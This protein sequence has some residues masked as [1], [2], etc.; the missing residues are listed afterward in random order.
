MSYEDFDRAMDKLWKLNSPEQEAY[1]DILRIKISNQE[2]Q[3]CKISGVQA[4]VARNKLGHLKKELAHVENRLNLGFERN[5]A[6]TRLLNATRKAREN[7]LSNPSELIEALENWDVFA[8]RLDRHLAEAAK[9]RIRVAR[10]RWPDASIKARVQL[11]RGLASSS[12]RRWLVWKPMNFLL[13]GLSKVSRTVL[14]ARL[15]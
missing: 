5:I 15:P 6:L 12:S 8:V 7:E 14:K 13:R 9:R 11:T 2:A 10:I 4:E 3:V 1:A